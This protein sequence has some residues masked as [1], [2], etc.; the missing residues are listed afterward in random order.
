METKRYGNYMKITATLILITFF[1]CN[2]RQSDNH[3]TEKI[4]LQSKQDRIEQKV[5]QT[6]F[7]EESEFNYGFL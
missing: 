6:I 4:N 7:G 3:L 2:N 1:S 5:K